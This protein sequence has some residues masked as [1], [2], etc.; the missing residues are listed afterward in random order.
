MHR[1][2]GEVQ[3]SNSLAQIDR[4]LHNEMSTCAACGMAGCMVLV[5]ESGWFVRMKCL[6]SV[7]SR[8]SG[9]LDRDWSKSKQDRAVH[10][11]D[12]ARIRM[13]SSHE[14]HMNLLHYE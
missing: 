9:T 12:L 10:D 7:G 5:P 11:V 6:L 3:S 13:P 1:L 8:Y 14:L 2:P 4:P